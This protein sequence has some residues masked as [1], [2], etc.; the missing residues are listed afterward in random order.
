MSDMYMKGKVNLHHLQ[1]TKSVLVCLLVFCS[2]TT[3]SRQIHGSVCVD[4]LKP[5]F[6][7]FSASKPFYLYQDIVSAS[8]NF[9]LQKVS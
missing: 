9:V 4:V 5:G 3:S 2:V 8:T 1:N 6:G 7:S